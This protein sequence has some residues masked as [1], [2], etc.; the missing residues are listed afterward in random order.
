MRPTAADPR[1]PAEAESG[2]TDALLS[3]RYRLR[4]FIKSGGMGELHEALDELSGTRV[5]VKLLRADL[6]DDR[7]L[8]RFFLEARTALRLA[9]TAQVVTVRDVG[10]APDLRPFFVMDYLVGQDLA[11]LLRKQGAPGAARAVALMLEVCQAV[12]GVHASGVIHRDLKPS[13][14][15]LLREGGAVRLLDFGISKT[16]ASSA[17]LTLT[18]TGELMGSLAYVAPER[19]RDPDDTRVSGDIWALGVMTYELLT[20]SLPYQGQNSEALRLA[21]ENGDPPSLGAVGEER[22]PEL[23]TVL[24]VALHKDPQYRYARVSDFESALRRAAFDAELVEEPGAASPERP[25]GA[26]SPESPV[27]PSMVSSKHRPPRVGAWLAVG[28]LATGVAAALSLWLGPTHEQL[29]EPAVNSSGAALGV[30]VQAPEPPSSSTAVPDSMPMREL[31]SA[32]PTP[33]SVT[34]SARLG[35]VPSAQP[36]R[37]APASLDQLPLPEPIFQSPAT[38]APP[39]PSASARAR[40]SQLALEPS[41]LDQF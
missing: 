15:F 27:S 7:S 8:C 2:A 24:R 14:V 10:F 25:V 22:F 11:E 19:L 20:G 6:I 17:E 30:P 31:P 23:D 29:P 26:T 16:L 18:R 36:S 41:D 32:L 4:R 13:N 9:G 5:A 12:A 38:P 21:I 34:R 1:V 37:K 39:V 3:G 40:G 28:V 35:S 33:A